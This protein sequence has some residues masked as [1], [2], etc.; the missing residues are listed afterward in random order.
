MHRTKN[1][2]VAEVLYAAGIRD[3]GVVIDTQGV[4]VRVGK[5]TAR[6]E[7]LALAVAWA[8]GFVAGRQ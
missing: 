1:Q 8:K 5:V 2:D 3:Y 4:K 6:F 7:S